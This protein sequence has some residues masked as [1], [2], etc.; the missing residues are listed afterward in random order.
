[1][2]DYS[3][4]VNFAAKDALISGNPNKAVQGT[5]L[6]TEFDNIATASNT[7]ADKASPTFTGTVN[8]AATVSTVDDA[9]NSATTSP[10][11]L[12]H[13]TSGTPA[14]G[15]GVS[16]DY[17]VETTAGNNETGMVLG[18]VVA[19]VTSTS[20]DFDFV[21]DLMAAGA[22]AAEKFRVSSAGVVTAAT[23]NGGL[24]G[25][26]IGDVLGNVQGNVTGNTS[27]TAATV[28]TA[29]QPAITSL[30]TLTSLTVDNV[31]VN[32]AAITSDTGAISF[33]DENLSTTGT[34]ASGALDVTG[35]ITTDGLAT[36]ADIT[37]G[38]NDKAIFGAGSDLQIYHDGSNSYVSEQGTGPLKFLS[39]GLQVKNAAD[40]ESMIVANQNGAVT[41]YH[42]N[43]AKLATTSTGIDVTGT[44]TVTTAGT[45]GILN[46]LSTDGDILDIRKDGTTIGKVGVDN[47]DNLFIEGDSTHSGLQ[48]G[49]SAVLPHKNGI[50]ANGVVDIGQA[51]SRFKDLYLSGDIT[52][53]GF[54]SGNLKDY[55]EITNAIGSTGGGTQDIDMTLGNSVTATV[56][57]SANTF[58][59]S[60]PTAS[61]ELCGFTLLLT[62]GGSQTVNWPASVDWP[63]G[64]APTLTAAGVDKLVFET[65]DGGT[66]WQGNA[67][68]LAY[69]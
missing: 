47:G 67:A 41:L 49:T 48:F 34:L 26:V 44:A 69:A 25:P 51:A 28:T 19:D 59:F 57:T 4:T 53:T 9:I 22:P 10:Q 6:N 2:A 46:R 7:K 43:A 13:T 12:I 36:S 17:V 55:G 11:Q 52:T 14:N 18:T 62:N 54:I 29:A 65:T 58:T 15:I 32:G 64:L 31:T 66:N 61:D 16:T 45:A 40:D 1:M 35:V 37:F 60:N 42:D 39:N 50:T 24:V 27:G 63:A 56:D 30:G 38:D 23:F 20:E 3:K 21:V 33:G 68:G 5:E 8:T